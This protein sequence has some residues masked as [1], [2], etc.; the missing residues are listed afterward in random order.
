MKLKV[1]D[2]IVYTKESKGEFY[3]IHKDV[4]AGDYTITKKV[5]KK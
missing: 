3:R 2:V 1:G 5:G 4:F